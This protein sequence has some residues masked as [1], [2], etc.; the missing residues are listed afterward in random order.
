MYLA[1]RLYE[2][3]CLMCILCCCQYST[4]K[5]KKYN[6]DH[7]EALRKAVID[8]CKKL[9]IYSNGMTIN[10]HL[11]VAVDGVKVLYLFIND[12]AKETENVS[13]IDFPRHV[14]TFYCDGLL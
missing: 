6:K 9:F 1:L 2:T 7:V 8:V 10:G 5:Q 3:D 14:R 13:I 11:N 4:S 12:F